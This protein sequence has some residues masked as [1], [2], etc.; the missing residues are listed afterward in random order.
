MGDADKLDAVFSVARSLFE[1][2]KMFFNEMMSFIPYGD[3]K[4]IG[5]FITLYHFDTPS[6]G[7]LDITEM[8]ADENGDEII[9]EFTIHQRKMA[10]L[11]LMKMII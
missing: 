10:H 8:S 11:L 3:M 5:E 4:E 1:E 7:Q 9:H 2:N 6:G